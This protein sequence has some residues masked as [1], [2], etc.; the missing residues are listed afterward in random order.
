MVVMDS[1]LAPSG[2]LSR[3][4]LARPGMTT[5]RT[6]ALGVAGPGADHAFLAA[7]IVALFGR[8]VQRGGNLRFYCVA[9]G[10]AGVGHVDGKRRAGLFHRNRGALALALLAGSR[11]RGSLG[12]IVDG[13][14][15]GAAFAD[16]E[17]AGGLRGAGELRADQRNN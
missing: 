10:A 13:L 9:M 8:G 16:G 15:I 7:K 12:R 14:A 3:E 11:K 2:A 1:G 17:C 4:P 5:M 6:S